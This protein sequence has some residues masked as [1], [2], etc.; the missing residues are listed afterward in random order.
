MIRKGARLAVSYLS[1]SDTTGVA[2]GHRNSKQDG[3]SQLLGHRELMY[4]ELSGAPLGGGVLRSL[5]PLCLLGLLGG[6]RVP[7]WAASFRATCP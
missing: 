2:Q 1:F 3:K 7:L 5:C 4:V 6:H